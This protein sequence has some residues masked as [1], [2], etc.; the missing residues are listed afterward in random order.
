MASLN[1]VI[2]IGNLGKDPELKTFENGGS[3]CNF[4]IATSESYK[5]KAGEKV[6]D[7]QWHNITMWNPLSEI[8]DKYLKKGSQVCIVGKVTSRS[9]EDKDGIKRYVTEIRANEMTMLGGGKKDEG[10]DPA[11]VESGSASTDGDDLPF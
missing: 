9:Y 7:T 4:S 10:A 8:A 5:N 2:L 3:V 1:K 11:P 6:T